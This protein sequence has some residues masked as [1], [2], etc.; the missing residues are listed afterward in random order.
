M[1]TREQHHIKRINSENNMTSLLHLFAA[2]ALLCLSLPSDAFAPAALPA[3]AM[4]APSSPLLPTLRAATPLRPLRMS[5]TQES[6]SSSS[7]A[8]DA[9]AD[10]GVEEEP[11]DAATRLALEKARKADLLRSQEVF[12][13]RS[14]GIHQCS[15]C[16]W[17]YS[18]EKGDSFLIGGMIKPGVT[19]DDLPSNWRCPTCR[20]SKDGFKEVVETI[21]GFEV[22]QGYGFGT[23]SMTSGQKNAL[24]W[25]GIG[26]FFL[27]FIGGYALS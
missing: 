9:A 13:K 25:G 8:A 3:R 1:H 23:N 20:S 19:F 18:P 24:I 2:G 12:M 26:G 21:P 10:G 4:V 11:V 7:V 15:N 14:T 22:N 17:E 5:E 27:L 16:G 6:T